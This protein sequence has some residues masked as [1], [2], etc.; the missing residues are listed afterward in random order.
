[1]HYHTIIILQKC[2]V[3]TSTDVARLFINKSYVL[4]SDSGIAIIDI[5][6][7]VNKMWLLILSIQC[8]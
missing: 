2:L 1:M 8:A 4:S 6:V 3:L 7:S 5:V